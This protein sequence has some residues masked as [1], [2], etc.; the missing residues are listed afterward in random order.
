MSEANATEFFTGGAKLV[1][2]GGAGGKIDPETLENAI[3]ARASEGVDTRRGP[4]SLTQV[5]DLGGVY[6]LDHIRALSA[7]AKR[8]GLPVHMDGAR[9]ANALVTLGCSPADMTWKA[10]V[11]VLS[12]GG[13]KNG[14]MAAEAVI[15]F[16]PELAEEFAIRRLR[17]G[18]MLSKQRFI[19]AQYEAYLQGD[20]WLDLARHA[21]EMAAHL[22]QG[23]SDLDGVH[24]REVRAANMLFVRL[25]EDAHLRAMKAGAMFYAG[26]AKSGQ[27][28]ARLVCNWATTEVDI[29]RLF[30]LFKGP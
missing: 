20:R 6:V 16:K 11:D 4:V 3:E 27:V 7:I 5:T 18:H 14:L 21:N 25:P 17:A 15:F 26:E 9:F 12:F 8:Y 22:E 23:L 24:M 1:T 30:E 19:A 29:A 10:G 2:L 13:T 28:D